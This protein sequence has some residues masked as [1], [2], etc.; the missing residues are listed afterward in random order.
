MHTA[1]NGGEIPALVQTQHAAGWSII[2][3]RADKRAFVAWKTYQKQRAPEAQLAEWARKLRPPCWAV[4]TG[5]ISG[6]VVLDFDGDQGRAVLERTGLNPHVRTG[7]GGFHVYV[8]HPGRAVKTVSALQPGLDVRGDGGYAVFAGKSIRGVYAQLRELTPLRFEEVP[9]ELAD[10][11]TSGSGAKENGRVSSEVLVRKALEIVGKEGRNSAGF[12][13]A[14]QLRDNGYSQQEAAGI[15][16]N[17]FR[18]RAGELNQKGQAEPYT[19]EEIRASVESAYSKPARGAW[20]KRTPDARK[21]APP[22]SSAA[23]PPPGPGPSPSDDGFELRPEGLFFIEYTGRDAHQRTVE[24]WLCPPIEVE[25]TARNIE[26]RGYGL[27]VRVKTS[28]GN[29]PRVFIHKTKLYGDGIESL[30]ELI[31][32]GFEPSRSKKHL[33]LLKDYLCRRERQQRRFITYAT[34]TG[35]HDDRFV[36]PDRTYGRAGQDEELMFHTADR[37]EHRYNLGGTLNGWRDRVARYCAGNSRLV[38]AVSAAFAAPLLYRLGQPNGGFHYR[39][40]SSV[41]KTT[42]LYVAGSVWGGTGDQRG[43]LRNWRATSNGLEAQAA[44]HNDA[45]L[46]LDEIGQASEHE[47][48]ETV[49]LIGNGQAKQRSTRGGGIRPGQAFRLF[50]MSTGERSIADMIQAGGGTMRAGHEVRMI[51]IPADAGAGSGL[52]EEL[53]HF[54]HGSKIANHLREATKEEYGHPIHAFLERLVNAE[55]TLQQEIERNVRTFVEKTL[56]A[57][58]AAEVSRMV[59]KFALVATAGELASRWG[60][61]GWRPGEAYRA[62]QSCFWALVESRGGVGAGDVERA[63]QSVVKFLETHQAS[64]FARHDG[65]DNRPSIPNLA[66]WIGEER[67]QENNP[68]RTFYVLP[69]IMDGEILKGHDVQGTVKEMA[70]RGLLRS[71]GGKN[72][73]QRRLS[74]PGEKIP[75]RRRVYVIYSSIFGEDQDGEEED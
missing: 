47:V 54:D 24:H 6:L 30:E 17:E 70:R 73:S 18:P 75:E 5:E 63:I 12:H 49:Y 39:G 57:G 13:L 22:A 68:R 71:K 64:R 66:G 51:E 46:L 32:A 38:L 26:D 40:G 44:L 55:P 60:I 20:E 62:S 28:S 2:P 61:T 14:A 9:K 69:G 16:A 19:D 37:S 52:F 53:H 43:F 1:T 36:L 4:V 3:T 31:D 59:D 11:M 27:I 58:A 10:M 25:G 65:S 29:T 67:D 41:G 15:V 56:P 45:L 21:A 8:Q 23:P 42:A 7:S 72:T 35:W 74:L 33:N 48:S 50:A 34:Q